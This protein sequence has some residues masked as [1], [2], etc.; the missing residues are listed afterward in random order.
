M[1]EYLIVLVFDMLNTK[2][3]VRLLSPNP[4]QRYAKPAEKA[5]PDIEENQVR[6]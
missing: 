3:C 6:V 5:D 4:L 1:F 2:P